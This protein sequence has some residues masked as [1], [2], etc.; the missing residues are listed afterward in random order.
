MY[1]IERIYLHLRKVLIPVGNTQPDHLI[2]PEWISDKVNAQNGDED[3]GA[4]TEPHPR[5]LP[6]VIFDQLADQGRGTPGNNDGQTMAKG[7]ER[8][9]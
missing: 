4:F 1:P 8:N 2:S 5:S 9:K 7:E 3:A 6:G